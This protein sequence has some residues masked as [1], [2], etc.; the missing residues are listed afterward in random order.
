M[1]AHSGTSSI[2]LPEITEL[3]G[4]ERAWIGFLR[5]LSGDTDPVPT[6]ARVQALRQ[7]LRE[8]GSNECGHDVGLPHS[9]NAIRK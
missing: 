5:L 2:F 7:A 1:S 4:N 8:R 3:T 9:S 6:L